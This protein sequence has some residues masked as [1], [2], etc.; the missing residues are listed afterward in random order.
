MENKSFPIYEKFIKDDEIN[1][2][3]RRVATYSKI[4][5]E[6]KKN[7]KLGIFMTSIPELADDLCMNVDRLLGY[8]DDLIYLKY[9]SWSF[10]YGDD[11]AVGVGFELAKKQ[12]KE[13]K[14]DDNK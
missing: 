8:I 13:S 14:D 3:L 6:C 12:D 7:K 4:F 2:D 10:Y 11:E 9:I 1:G 5:F